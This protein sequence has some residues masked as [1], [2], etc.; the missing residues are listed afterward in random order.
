MS[1]FILIILF[2]W[3]V[4]SNSK[5][6]LYLSALRLRKSIYYSLSQPDPSLCYGTELFHLNSRTA[7]FFCGDIP[8]NPYL[9]P[10]ENPLHAWPQPELIEC[11]SHRPGFTQNL[12]EVLSVPLPRPSA[13]TLN[14][15]TF[16]SDSWETPP[17][18]SLLGSVLLI[19]TPWPKNTHLCEVHGSFCCI[20]CRPVLKWLWTQE[21]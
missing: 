16:R 5:V 13:L 6:S 21:H 7:H 20:W 1:V 11:S 17:A 8:L 18:V 3:R 19:T 14:R 4:I 2:D 15:I 9:Q 10:F 12:A